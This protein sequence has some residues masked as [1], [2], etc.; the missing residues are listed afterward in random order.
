[1]LCPRSHSHAA[2]SARQLLLDFTDE[3]AEPQGVRN[4]PR[5]VAEPA[6]EAWWVRF[7]RYAQVP[8]PRLGLSSHV[9]AN[10]PH[11]SRVSGWGTCVAGFQALASSA[12]CDFGFWPPDSGFCALWVSLLFELLTCTVAAS[13]LKQWLLPSYL[14]PEGPLVWVHPELS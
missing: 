6:C 2:H 11:P 3:E 9:D 12:S 1:M 13:F 14:N 8:W 7:W 4:Q 10:G 5:L